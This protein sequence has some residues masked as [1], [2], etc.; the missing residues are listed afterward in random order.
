VEQELTEWAGHSEKFILYEGFG[1]LEGRR[2]EAG[3]NGF[4]VQA[5]SPHF[6]LVRSPEQLYRQLEAAEKVPIEIRHSENVLTA[7]TGV[8]SRVAPSAPPPRAAAKKPAKI[9]RSVRTTLWFPD[10]EIHAAFKRILLDAK[11]VV[12]T[13]ARALTV[14]YAKEAEPLV[15]EGLKKLGE[16]YAVAVEEAAAAASLL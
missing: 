6:A 9:R 5:I 7:P 3:A 16:H 1:L 12:P 8:R 13:D 10:A 14:T 11:C 15:K 4:V 2:D